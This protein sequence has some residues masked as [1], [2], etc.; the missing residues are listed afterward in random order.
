MATIVPATHENIDRAADIIRRGG[1]VGFPTETV[2]G[3]GANAL[4]PEAVRRIYAAKGRPPSNP[5]IVHLAALADLSRVAAIPPGSVI[6]E[7]IDTLSPLWPGPLSLVLPRRDL[8]PAETTAGHPSVAVRVPGHQVARALIAAAGVPIAAPSANV[9]SYISPTTAHHVAEGL[10]D[11]VDLILDGGP[12][13]VGLESTVL[14]LVHPRPTV[15]RHGGIP[16]E[17]L[18]EILGDVD[19]IAL[20]SAGTDLP[21]SPGL[22][23]QHYSP[24]TKL[25]F[26][27]ELDP[28]RY[29]SRTALITFSPATT[30]LPQT[31]V[32]VRTLSER[33]D[34]EEA[35]RELF[36]AL[37]ELDGGGFAL[38]VVEPCPRVGL[39]RAIMDR[40]TRA[41]AQGGEPPTCQ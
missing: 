32:A 26:A 34:L 20:E 12:C 27:G 14:S 36:G 22:L 1:L 33:G 13:T 10:G 30:P 15:L 16:I 28:A 7:R 29:P 6:A 11:K 8:L 37:R 17:K 5:L 9:S 38:I 19:E 25:V 21:L 23:R 24:R 35:A 39:G 4:D 18:R 2:Y 41:A 40:L 31:V 3:L